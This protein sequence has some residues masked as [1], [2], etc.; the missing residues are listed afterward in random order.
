MN[1]K[2]RRISLSLRLSPPRQ[3][4]LES[5][6]SASPLQCL[7]PARVL[8]EP[9]SQPI[10]H[11]RSNPILAQTRP[12]WRGRP[13]APSGGATDAISCDTAAAIRSDRVCIL[14]TISARFGPGDAMVAAIVGD[15]RIDTGASA[16]QAAGR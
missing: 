11:R 1:R 13:G 4:R 5:D 16:H 8:D 6:Y 2:D 3:W 10:K 15:T 7:T 12:W 14:V 9:C